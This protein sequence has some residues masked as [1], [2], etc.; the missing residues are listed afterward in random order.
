MERQLPLTSYLGYSLQLVLIVNDEHGQR[1]QLLG[2]LFLGNLFLW[3]D[4]VPIDL[5]L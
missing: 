5:S 1:G 2:F 4:A 3:Q